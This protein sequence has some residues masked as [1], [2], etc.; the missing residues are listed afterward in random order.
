MLQYKY[1]ILRWWPEAKF[2]SLLFLILLGFLWISSEF[3]DKVLKLLFYT[4]WTILKF[5]FIISGWSYIDLFWQMVL[6]L[7]KNIYILYFLTIYLSAICIFVY[8][9]TILFIVL[10]KE[11][12]TWLSVD[13][14]PSCFV[15]SLFW[16]VILLGK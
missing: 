1:R 3:M 5:W 7:L 11:N 13:C 2:E 9:R 6:K 4:L 14:I 15:N 8:L 10:S 16:M 12:G